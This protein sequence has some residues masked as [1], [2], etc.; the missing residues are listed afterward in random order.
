MEEHYTV[1]G[2]AAHMWRL[3]TSLLPQ[4]T[5]A[6]RDALLDA[7][8][9][10]CCNMAVDCLSIQSLTNSFLAAQC[11]HL[12]IS[13]SSVNFGCSVP[14]RQKSYLIGKVGPFSGVRIH[15]YHMMHVC[16]QEAISY[17][18]VCKDFDLQKAEQIKVCWGC[19]RLVNTHLCILQPTANVVLLKLSER[20]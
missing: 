16:T 11:V 6:R 3:Q 14:H 8:N 18:L 5:P 17:Y 7:V 13:S 10:A 1:D 19:T 12:L 20:R 15:S 4:A 9:H 2:S